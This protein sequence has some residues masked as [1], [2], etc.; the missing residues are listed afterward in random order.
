MGWVRDLARHL[1]ADPGTAEDVAQEAWLAART[2]PPADVRSE[3]QLR[4]WLGVVVRN[5]VRRSA[6]S[7]GRRGDREARAARDEALEPTADVVAR[8]ALAQDLTR[9][10][11]ELDDP[12]RSAILL[13]YFDGLSTAEV[14][15]RQG[16]SPAAARKRLSR[17]LERLRA[18]LDDANGGDRD[19]WTM[20]LLPLI[21]VEPAA[22][23]AA[24]AGLGTLTGVLLVNAKALAALSAVVLLALVLALD[25]LGLFD[26]AEP[27]DPLG[28][29]PGPG[30]TTSGP[31]LAGAPGP[32]APDPAGAGRTAE[33]LARLELVDGAGAAVADAWVARLDGSDLAP[34]GRTDATGALDLDE[35]H[36]DAAGPPALLVAGR[37]RVPVRLALPAGPGPWRLVLDE[38]LVLAGRLEGAAIPADLRLP[39]AFDREHAALAGL[40]P[41]ALA[42]LRDAGVAPDRVELTP[43]PGGRVRCAGLPAD[44]SGAVLAPPGFRLGAGAAP[45]H[46]LDDRELLLLEPA[47][48]LRLPLVALRSVRGRVVD[49]SDDRPAAGLALRLRTPGETGVRVVTGA[50]GRFEAWPGPGDAAVTVTLED[51]RA[52]GGPWTFG[53]EELAGDAAATD[54]GDLPV[55]LGARVAYFVTGP[56]GAPVAGARGHVAAEGLHGTVTD[57]D[58]HGS[59]TGVRGAAPEL[60]VTAPGHALAKVPV[61]LPL[62]EVAARV[63]L[64]PASSL[65]VRVRDEDGLV[66]EDL[67]VR[68]RGEEDLWA[69]PFGTGWLELDPGTDPERA[70]AARAD[71]E[72][73]RQPDG[74]GLVRVE[75]LVPGR[76][77]DVD[78]VTAAGDVV[79]SRPVATPAPG[80]PAAEL[81]LV[82]PR[83]GYLVEGLARDPEGR[84][85][86]RVRVHAETRR[87]STSV[88]TDADGRFALG[89]YREPVRLTYLEATRPGYAAA[90]L[91]DLELGPDAAPLDLVL[92]PARRLTV[93]LVDALGRRPDVP[94]L[95]AEL[96]GGS[97]H[98]G[99]RGDEPGTY[100][101]DA[102]PMLPGEVT[103]DLAGVTARVAIDGLQTEVLL[104]APALGV[105]EVRLVAGTEAPSGARLAVA[106][107]R[108][109]AGAVV[110]DGRTYLRVAGEGF[111]PLALD[112]PPGTY[113][114]TLEQR[115]LARRLVEA[116]G[117]TPVVT[118]VAGEVVP[119]LLPEAP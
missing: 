50:D 69:E 59:L 64:R 41:A 103:V 13:R 44:W 40:A 68:V 116:L 43:G 65:V 76:A 57:A 26:G 61:P 46:L 20:A 78:L 119:L 12:Y 62:G 102:L 22:T 94:F 110:A 48:D 87:G 70:R 54:L 90:Q 117:A 97:G 89:P 53:T 33:A 66:P 100:V 108:L 31:E 34:L 29:A 17:G 56:D 115:I 113:R 3:G 111:E 1:V 79:L 93:T 86:P 67:F 36:L 10:V 118:V 85:L 81:D 30:A 32:G 16:T 23:V 84:P 74:E 49:A 19:A 99:L 18:R 24:G 45:G 101:F 5:L 2:A 88:R 83:R 38:G 96:A 107:E 91:R 114:V 60:T 27:V 35:T 98:A 28:P 75:P 82:V 106:W 6:R 104:E 77:L 80:A 52:L 51:P 25:P 14:A 109:E 39:L 7:A 11:M 71:L 9:R 21:R 112:L 4:A 73:P 37:D 8:A 42:L 105:V 63:T 47:A 92:E 15:E 55:D 72:G 58:G 95:E